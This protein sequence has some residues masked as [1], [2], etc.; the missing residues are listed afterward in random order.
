MLLAL[1]GESSICFAITEEVTPGISFPFGTLSFLP[2]LHF[3]LQQVLYLLDQ[4]FDKYHLK[5]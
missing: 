4:P 2:W 1:L 5:G 3:K